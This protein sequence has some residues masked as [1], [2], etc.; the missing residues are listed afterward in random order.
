MR[1]LPGRL[2]GKTVDKNGHRG[3]VLTLATREQHIRREKASSNICSNNSLNALT[4][5]MYMASLGKTGLRSIAQLNH[6]KAV[7]L[8]NSLEEAGFSGAFTSPFFNEFVVKVPQGFKEKREA[9]Q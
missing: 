6:D 1:S 3:F 2:I 5:A 4:A 9:L 7:F 8:K